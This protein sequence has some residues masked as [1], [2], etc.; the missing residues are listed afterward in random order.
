M[1]RTVDIFTY[2]SVIY[3]K[4]NN[5]EI[6]IGAPTSNFNSLLK[7]YVC[8]FHKNLPGMGVILIEKQTYGCFPL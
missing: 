2:I 6:G 7:K 3:G 4:I 1:K 8:P 5:L